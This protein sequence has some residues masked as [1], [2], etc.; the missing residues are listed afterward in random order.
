M[1]DYAIVIKACSKIVTPCHAL[2]HRECCRYCFQALLGYLLSIYTYFFMLGFTGLFIVLF[3]PNFFLLGPLRNVN[4]TASLGQ[5]KRLSVF[6]ITCYTA[7]NFSH[8]NFAHIVSW[9][10]NHAT[11]VY[12][13]EVIETLI[14]GQCYGYFYLY[15]V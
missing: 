15:C 1:A 14:H 12:L 10:S 2:K 7:I 11:Y 5:A 13:P 3:I 9:T 6:F 4:F 8:I